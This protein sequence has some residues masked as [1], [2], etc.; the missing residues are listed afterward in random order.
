MICCY[1][2]STVLYLDTGGGSTTLSVWILHSTPK[3]KILAQNVVK[4]CERKELTLT[5]HINHVS[6]Y[7]IQI[8]N[9]NLEA[10]KD[11]SSC[12]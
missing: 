10:K 9:T 11:K 4:V 1:A 6:K 7:Q 2:S 8:R 12:E 5:H 3:S